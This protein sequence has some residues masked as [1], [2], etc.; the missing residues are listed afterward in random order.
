[1]MHVTGSIRGASALL[2][3]VLGAMLTGCAGA[4]DRPPTLTLRNDALHGVEVHF[5]VL[6]ADGNPATPGEAGIQHLRVPGGGVLTQEVAD[7]TG[8]IAKAPRG[9][10]VIRA[11]V[12]LEGGLEILQVVDLAPP[13]PFVLRASPFGSGVKVEEVVEAE[14]DDRQMRDL[15]THQPPQPGRAGRP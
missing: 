8:A 15:T 11:F 14:V 13:A 12:T 7:P 1:M 6:A 9:S 4:P 10:T 2:L 5:A 3:G